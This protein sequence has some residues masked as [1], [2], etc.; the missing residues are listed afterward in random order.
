MDALVEKYYQAPQVQLPIEHPDSGIIKIT[1]LRVLC[2]RCEGFTE[3]LRGKVTI[4]SS[5]IELEVGGDCKECRAITWT[6]TRMYAEHILV[7]SDDGI[8]TINMKRT[9]WEKFM[10]WFS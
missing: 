9:R 8:K 4:H 10:R 7:W 3:D 2:K 6:R 5:C 1:E